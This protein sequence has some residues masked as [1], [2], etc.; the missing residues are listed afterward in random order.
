MTSLLDHQ[1]ADGTTG[2]GR[3]RLT[4][5]GA[6]EVAGADR[7]PLLAVVPDPRDR[8]RRRVSP[9]VRRRRT[10]LAVTALALV[11]L[12]LPLSG[13]G[14]ASHPTGP[15]PAAT[16]GPVSYVVQPGDTLAT[17]V[18]RVDPGVD[19]APVVA[20]IAG[21]LGSAVVVPGE[22]ITVP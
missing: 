18:E 8:A 6:P 2:T 12:A 5:V 4:L 21:E 14:G 22:R 17:I 7:P 13:T 10:L 3:P 19:P 1:R 16:G 9:A 11:G 15:A 20:R